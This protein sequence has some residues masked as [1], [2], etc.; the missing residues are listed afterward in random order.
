M[1][2]AA[3]RFLKKKLHDACPEVVELCQPTAKELWKLLVFIRITLGVW[4]LWCSASRNQSW[5]C[6]HPPA[7]AAQA[8]EPA[9]TV[10]ASGSIPPRPAA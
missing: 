5:R 9:S 1:P 4:K 10:G 8:Q 2:D 6:H 7:L 3:I